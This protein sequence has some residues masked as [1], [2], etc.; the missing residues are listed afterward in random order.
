MGKVFPRE[1]Q[2]PG[3]ETR[4]R[5]GIPGNRNRNATSRTGSRDGTLIAYRSAGQDRSIAD[6]SRSPFSTNRGGIMKG[7]RSLSALVAAGVLL[8]VAGTSAAA[9]KN[10]TFTGKFT[11]NRG[12]LINIPVVGD[13]PCAG[14]G[15]VQPADH[16]GPR[17]DRAAHPGQHDLDDDAAESHT[18]GAPVQS[19]R[20][21]RQGR[22]SSASGSMP[23]RRSP[24]P[25]AGVGGTFVVPTKALMHP[26]PG[27]TTAIHVQERHPGRSSSPRAS[28]SRA[29]A[30]AT[31]V[32]TAPPTKSATGGGAVWKANWR[33][34]QKNAHLDAAGSRSGRRCSATAGASRAAPT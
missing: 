3:S 30:D 25:G 1:G 28:R 33:K 13:T 22:L 19:V 23:A 29:R 31:L 14:V 17:S 8:L 12:I 27:V 32:M 6:R 24:P 7:I 2:G 21:R 5:A 10:Y 26:L 15:P 18:G 20:E 16:V 9:P 34:F 4:A 11:S